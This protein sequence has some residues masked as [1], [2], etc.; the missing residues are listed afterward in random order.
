L[1]R[2]SFMSVSLSPPRPAAMRAFSGEARALSN[3]SI[4]QPEAAA[5]SVV[6]QFEI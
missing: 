5:P 2:R 3:T 1:A 4:G 6:G